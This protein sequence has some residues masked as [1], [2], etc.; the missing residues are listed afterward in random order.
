MQHTRLKLEAIAALLLAS[1]ASAAVPPTLTID[2]A[3]VTEGNSGTVVLRFFVRIDQSSTSPISAVFT[4]VPLTGASF[5]PP[6]GGAA[7]GQPGVDYVN[8]GSVPINI[9]ANIVPAALSVAVTVCGDAFSEPDEQL[10]VNLQNVQGAQCF[11]GTCNGIGTIRNDGDTTP[12]PQSTLAVDDVSVT[13][14]ASGSKSAAFTVR[15]RAASAQTVTVDY[16]TSDGTAKSTGPGTGPWTCPMVDYVGRKGRLT[17][18][19]GEVSKTVSPTI[20]GGDSQAESSETFNLDLSNATGTTIADP[21][22]VATIRNF[23]LAF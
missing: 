10:F 8:P 22:G 14:P 11:E 18:A 3:S 2:D 4:A 9:P 6:I 17:F 20:C 23:G 12:M 19:S 5:H 15:L 7:C 13:E 1:S 21:R 16:A